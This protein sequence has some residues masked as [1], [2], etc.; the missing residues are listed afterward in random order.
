MNS[1]ATEQ[2]VAR[3]RERGFDARS[4]VDIDAGG[5][6]DGRGV[7]IHGICVLGW[8]Y[9]DGRWEFT[10][11]PPRLIEPDDNDPSGRWIWD[12][13]LNDCCRPAASVSDPAYMIARQVAELLPADPNKPR[14]QCFP[15]L[16]TWNMACLNSDEA[17]EECY[18]QWPDHLFAELRPEAAR[19]GYTPATARLADYMCSPKAFASFPDNTAADGTRIYHLAPD[20]PLPAALVSRLRTIRIRT[21]F[22]TWGLIGH[23]CDPVD[24]PALVDELNQYLAWD[25]Q[26]LG[27][28]SGEATLGLD[29]EGRSHPPPEVTLRVGPDG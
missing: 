13:I 14:S 4:F 29:H 27:A 6:Q 9:P 20:V 2:I 7:A 12:D 18:R 5:V 15:D 19:A 22:S 24:W 25:H 10:D 23:T 17:P 26:R 16:W 3:L 11:R 8:R 21:D 1:V 28:G